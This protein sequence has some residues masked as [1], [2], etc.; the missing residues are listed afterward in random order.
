MAS[1]QSLQGIANMVF[2]IGLLGGVMGCLSRCRSQGLKG[3]S[4]VLDA[5]GRE[6]L[7][8]RRARSR[9][10]CPGDCFMRSTRME[11]FRMEEKQTRLASKPLIEPPSSAFW[12]LFRLLLPRRRSLVRP[13][14]PRC[15]PFALFEVYSL[16]KLGYAP[17]GGLC[18]ALGDYAGAPFLFKIASWHQV[19]DRVEVFD[20]IQVTKIAGVSSRLRFI[21]QGGLTERP[22]LRE[23]QAHAGAVEPG[24]QGD[25]ELLHAP[26]RGARAHGRQ[27]A[28]GAREVHQGSESKQLDLSRQAVS[29]E[30]LARLGELNRA[31]GLSF[32]EILH[33]FGLLQSRGRASHTDHGELEDLAKVGFPLAPE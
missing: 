29:E 26:A 1:I 23:A 4:R 13:G 10:D 27:A 19:I 11:E 25:Q 20:P 33:A 16:G 32:T 14:P 8:S 28:A 31:A 7:G 24:G 2:G 17:A 3:E 30:V 12:R 18:E 15:A 6:M 21:S 22:G 9:L 5:V